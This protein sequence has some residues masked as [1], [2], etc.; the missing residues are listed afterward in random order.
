MRDD[1]VIVH[2]EA[3][4]LRTLLSSLLD[5]ALR[6]AGS[7]GR[8]DICVSRTPTGALL[9][10][11][12]TGPGIP[13]AE[14]SRVFDRFY[15]L[16][17]D[18]TSGSGLGLAIVKNIADAHGATVELAERRDGGSGL[19]VVVTFPAAAPAMT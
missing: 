15:R 19:R 7:P 10:V 2:G 16:P 1:A 13:A 11:Q 12:D 6:H 9:E 8:V 17:G 18:Q 5:N 14:R 3:Q 4:A